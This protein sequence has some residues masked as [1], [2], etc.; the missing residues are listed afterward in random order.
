MVARRSSRAW[1]KRASAIRRRDGRRPDG[2][3]SDGRRPGRPPLGR[4]P[5]G[6]AADGDGRW[7]AAGRA[8]IVSQPWPLARTRTHA[9][10]LRPAVRD[11]DPVEVFGPVVRLVLAAPASAADRYPTGNTG[12]ARVGIGTPMPLPDDLAGLLRDAGVA[13][14]PR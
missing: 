14:E 1:P 5:T 9:A 12:R 7:R 10:R 3:L 13:L 2:R 8:H 4:P 11:R 6:T